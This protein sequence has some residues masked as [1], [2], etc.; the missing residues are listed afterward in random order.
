MGLIS[1]LLLFPIMGPVHGFRFVLER[2]RDDAEAALRD[3]GRAF[4]ELIDLSMRH[5]AGQ[6]TDAEFAEQEAR[7]LERLNAIR[8]YRDGLLHGDPMEGEDAD[9]ARDGAAAYDAA[10]YDEAVDDEATPEA[11]R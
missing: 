2:L 1:G 4:A 3:E 7:L 6:L 10:A 11:A 5:G 9:A 8:E